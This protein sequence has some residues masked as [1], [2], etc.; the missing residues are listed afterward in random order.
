[1]VE[2]VREVDILEAARTN[3]V[4]ELLK[5]LEKQ[6]VNKE[7]RYKETPLM[8]AMIYGNL[9]AAR[10][11]VEKG[12]NIE[13]TNKWNETPFISAVCNLQ[14]DC[15]EYLLSIGANPYTTCMYGSNALS[16]VVGSRRINSQT[17]EEKA[18]EVIKLLLEKK[19]DLNNTNRF[20][21]TAMS[22]AES[23]RLWKIT[24]LLEQNGAKRTRMRGAM[25]GR[26]ED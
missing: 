7:D 1:M 17:S 24:D 20:G 21:H 6:D 19:V 11:L 18:C 8:M 4:N 3:D 5:C 10:V 2:V 25:L 13:H 23:R 26:D 22:I 9:E 12:A 14:I 16:A 15:I